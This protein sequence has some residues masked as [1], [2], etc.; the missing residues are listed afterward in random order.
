MVTLE[1]SY[2]INCVNSVLKELIMGCI[3][4]VRYLKEK[5][6]KYIK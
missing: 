1:V 2:A 5:N 3:K 6:I 4:N